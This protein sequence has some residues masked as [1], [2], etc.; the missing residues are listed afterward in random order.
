MRSIKRIPLKTVAAAVVALSSVTLAAAP[1]DAWCRCHHRVYHHRYYRHYSRPY[2]YYYGYGYA[3]SYYYGYSPSLRL[4]P[5]Y[6]CCYR[7]VTYGGY[8]WHRHY[9]RPAVVVAF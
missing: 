4:R 1:A 2:G 3:P 5:C 7:I 9:R 8:Y 6:G